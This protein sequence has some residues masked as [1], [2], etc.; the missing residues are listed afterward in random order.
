MSRKRRISV[1]AM[2]ARMMLKRMSGI[3]WSVESGNSALDNKSE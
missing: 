3:R 1:L 2:T